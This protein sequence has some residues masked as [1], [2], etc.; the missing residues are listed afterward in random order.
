MAN[1]KMGWEGLAYYGVAGSTAAT[2]IENSR[3]IKLDLDCDEGD[4]TVRGDSSAPP[5]ETKATTVRKLGVEIVM[6]NDIT[7]TV[8]AAI[9]Q[10]AGDGTGVALRLKDYSSGKG[11]DADFNVKASTTWNLNGEQ[12]VTFTFTASRS[13]GRSPERYV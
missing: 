7:D 5:I 9:M 6:I 4:T 12:V 1:V 13:Y 8:F 11:P 3:D 2:L 10:A